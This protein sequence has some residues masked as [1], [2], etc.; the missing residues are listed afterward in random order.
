LQPLRD[1]TAV[2][3][4]AA[5]GIGRALALACAAE[6]MHVALADVER[7][8]LDDA[9]REVC[10]AGAR[11]IGV[12]TDVTR[13]DA[14]RELADRTL[15]EFG[16]VHL[17][18]NNAGVFAAGGSVWETPLVDFEWQFA[19]NVM[20]IVHG[21]R[22]FVPILLEQGEPAHVLNTVSMAA[23]TT[24]PLSAGYFA[25]K[26]AALSLSESLYH[27]LSQRGAPVGVSVLCPE[28]VATRIGDSERNRPD[29]FARKHD[30]DAGEPPERTL[31][32]AAIREFTKAGAAPAVLAA[33]ALAAVRENRFYV[34]APPGS[35]W[36]RA[37]ETRLDD[38]RSERNP[39]FVPTTTND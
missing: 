11:A 1:R 34:L 5:S 33:R 16:A 10:A 13:P 23:L 14:L 19:V 39:T 26:H 29:S 9:V 6:G 28:I 15:E 22:V 3:T 25:S 35:G 37:C 17:L 18:C 20:G 7:D 31:V 4:G 12:V 27:E 38:I 2:V 21:L 8:G 24:G 30:P 36:R 32:A